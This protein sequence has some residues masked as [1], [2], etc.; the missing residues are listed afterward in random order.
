MRKFICFSAIAILFLFL[1]SPKVESQTVLYDIRLNEV[2]PN[3]EGSDTDYEWIEIFNFS[4]VSIDLGSCTIDGR[5][6]PEDTSI[7]E[8]DYLIVTRDI[9]DKDEDGKSFEERWGDGSGDWGDH[10][11]EIYPI[12]E[13]GISMSNS[14]D[15]VILECP[16]FEDSFTWSNAESG[17]SY[18]FS[19]DEEW[20][21]NF[22]I[23]PG[24]RNESVPEVIYSHDLVITE[25]YPSPDTKLSET[26]WLEIYNYDESSI[27]LK[28]WTL[29]DNT[30]NMAIDEEVIITSNSYMVFDSDFLNFTLNN[31]GEVISLFDP[32]EEIVDSFEYLNT[33]RQ[34]SNMRKFNDGKYGD[35]IFQTQ[36]ATY[37]EENIHIDP[38][39]VF[40]GKERSEIIDAKGMKIGDYVLIEGNVTVELGLLGEKVFYIQDETA[41]IQ[42]YLKDIELWQSYKTSHKLKIYGELK[43]S[44]GE[45]KI[46]VN[47]KNAI[48]KIDQGREVDIS[49]VNICDVGSETVGNLVF[50]SGKIIETSGKTFYIG[51]ED[52]SIKVFIK[53][54]SGIEVPDKHK[55][56]YAGIIG[57]I[58][59]YGNR[60]DSLR[61]LPRY[62]SDITIS[63]DPVEYGEV[64]A[65]TGADITST[66][67]M[68]SIF[69]SISLIFLRSE[70]IQ[71]LIGKFL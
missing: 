23:T 59:N 32:N 36:V 61:I 60:K 52:C 54:S 22:S 53:E 48:A 24:D 19:E 41:G 10:E 47:D 33:D 71:S 28:G 70:V 55:G 17:Q 16:G 11:S 69:I 20:V 21:D 51:D 1:S 46:Y 43:E 13:L 14:N 31:S 45:A 62:E 26:E 67:M 3:P 39:D 40:Y 44:Y 34:I 68:G 64:L 5:N 18:S 29:S 49:K 38:G 58:S 37:L 57:I 66:L 9:L 8:N 12:I 63:D 27:N 42:V 56:Q 50:L 2:M 7:N 15:L 65:A 35:E 4:S 6:F 30:K 25:V